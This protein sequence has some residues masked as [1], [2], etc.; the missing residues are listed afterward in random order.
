MLKHIVYWTLLPEAEGRTAAENA[1]ALKERCLPL[2]GKVPGLQNLEVSD[3]IH[4]ATEKVDVILQ[5]CHDDAAAY[6][7]YMKH[8]DHLLVIDFCGKISSA[9]YVV[10]YLV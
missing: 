6:E 3:Q 10:N 7:L 9:C 4:S 1:V 2:V 5:S 8:P